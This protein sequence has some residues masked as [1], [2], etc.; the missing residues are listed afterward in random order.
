MA[1]N[2]MRLTNGDRQVLRPLCCSWRASSPKLGWLPIYSCMGFGVTLITYKAVR[3]G[4]PM[5]RGPALHVPSTRT[6][7]QNTPNASAF[8]QKLLPV[9]FSVM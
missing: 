7:S 9:W 4:R 1:L 3:N 5:G 2:L 8:L 6:R